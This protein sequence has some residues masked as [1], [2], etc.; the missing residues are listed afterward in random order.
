MKKYLVLTRARVSAFT[1]LAALMG[2]AMG[3]GELGPGS[4]S[5]A[6]GVYL[7]A[8]G[9]S[10]LNQIS[11]RRTDSL[12]KRTRLRPLPGGTMGL[13]SA[14]MICLFSIAA[15]LITIG[16][17]TDGA[18]ALVLALC[19]LLIYNGIYTPLK[20]LSWLAI[21]VGALAGALPPAIGWAMSGTGLGSPLL[22]ALCLLFYLWQMPHFWM[23]LARHGEDYRRAGLPTLAD[24]LTH[25]QL[26]RI[27]MT[28]IAAT[29]ASSLMLPLFGAATTSGALIL[30][31]AAS[32]FLFISGIVSLF[33]ASAK[34]EYFFANS[35]IYMLLI[36]LSYIA[37]TAALRP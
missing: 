8:S 19:A 1:G 25:T 27:S 26:R 15:G 23:L 33:S 21:L 22:L 13:S 36:M 10:A 30:A 11:E 14:W 5:A 16:A 31:S 29:S 4:I 35:N 6:L 28:W 32:A 9:A 7:L 12:M 34:R 18:A 17:G 3:A 24:R 37:G 2:H 20:R